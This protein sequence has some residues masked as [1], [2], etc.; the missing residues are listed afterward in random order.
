M[1]PERG[2]NTATS[3]TGPGG[4]VNVS[5][6]PRSVVEKVV[7]SA[8]GFDLI[9]TGGAA[10]ILQ[11]GPGTGTVQEGNATFWDLGG[12]TD[13]QG[14]IPVSNDTYSGFLAIGFGI[15]NIRDYA[16]TADNLILPF[17]STDAY[18]TTFDT[19]GDGINDTLAI[20]RTSTDVVFI[21]G[22]L[23]PVNDGTHVQGH[24]E[25]IRLP[26]V[27][28]TSAAPVLLLALVVTLVT[29]H[30]VTRVHQRSMR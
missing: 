8:S 6:D 22:H 2:A 13:A 12:Y 16:G 4:T 25:T 30:P 1:F 21:E 24:L 3:P 5:L 17:A 19:E 10:N 15:V 7:G 11:P 27:S 18:F 26:T 23:H 29:P 9:F 14:S 20:M 28:S